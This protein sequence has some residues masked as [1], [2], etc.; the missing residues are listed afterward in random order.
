MMAGYTPSMHR[1]FAALRLRRVACDLSAVV[2]SWPALSD[3]QRRRL[4]DAFELVNVVAAE[5]C[6]GPCSV[7][8]LPASQRCNPCTA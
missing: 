1:G 5:V 7:T 6:P 3:D 8:P 2:E 4:Q